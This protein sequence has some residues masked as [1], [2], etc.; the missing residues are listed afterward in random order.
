MTAVEMLNLW[1]VGFEVFASNSAPG[2][3]DSDIYILLNRAQDLIIE[4]LVQQKDWLRLQ[5]VLYEHMGVPYVESETYFKYLAL[6]S[7]YQ[8][9]IESYSNISRTAISSSGFLGTKYTD[10]KLIKNKDISFDYADKFHSN[11]FNTL[12]VFKEPKAFINRGSI[13]VIT[14][15]YTTVNY[16]NIRYIKKRREIGVG[17]CELD[18]PLHRIVVEKAIDLGKKTIF[19]Q[20]PQS[21]N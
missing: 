11:G 10:A 18:E 21:S 19:I 13:Y 3:E 20:E 16:I 14:D 12:N 1:K 15:S 2:F 17:N 9:Y 6:P 7:D 4:E 5:A 8:Y